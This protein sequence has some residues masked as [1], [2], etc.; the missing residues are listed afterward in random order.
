[1]QRVVRP[2]SRLV[3]VVA[4]PGDKSISHRTAMLAAVAAG[5][6]RI[7][8][9][10]RGADCLATLRCL[11][12]LGVPW[13]WEDGTTLRVEG[14]GLRGLRE[15]PQVLDCGNSGTTMRLLAGLLAPQPFLSVLTGDRSLRR[16]PMARVVEPLRRMGAEVWGRAEG[17]LAPLAIR[18]RPLRGIEH[19]MPV[20]SAQVKSAL[21]L[22][23]LY[24]EGETVV[25]E[26]APCRDHTERLLAFMGAPVRRMEGGVA[27]S[28]A[29][30]LQ[31]LEVR[32][33]GD[34]SAAAF[35]LVAALVHPEAEVRLE[36]V[37]IN[38]TRTGL[39][40]VVL[41]M[42]AQ[43]RVENGRQWGPEPVADLVARSSS[44]RAVAVG[45]ELL[46]RLIDEV[47]LLAVAAC[48]ARGETVIRGAQELR[49]KES[50]RLRATARE[51][52]RLGA[53]VEELPDGLRIW[54]PTLLRGAVVD[55]HGDHRLAMALAVA[56]LAARGETVIR[57]SR[58]VAV[59]YPNFWGDLESLTAVGE[60]RGQR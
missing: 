10:Q 5:V 34:F 39:L 21:L 30:S 56:A 41:E 60:N 27:V 19:R 23:G 43:V 1:V 20:A 57:N 35:F 22:A 6:S 26:P 38:P 25:W 7:E 47:P 37:G 18:G 11:R 49:A 44:L 4:P 55:S 52:R 42:G 32:V 13:R 31:P 33:P 24:A 14:V 12:L 54:G 40:D 16:R 8:N 51:L 59:S 58:A 46:P 28:S 53:R 15:P 45:G 17:S 50:D 2:A 48:F 29:S 9:F 3:G 36:G